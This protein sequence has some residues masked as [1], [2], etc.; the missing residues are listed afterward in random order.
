V[1]RCRYCECMNRVR[2]TQRTSALP[3]KYLSYLKNSSS[4][5]LAESNLSRLLESGGAKALEKIPQADLPTLFAVLGGSAYLSD[6]LFR[7]GNDWPAI[8]LRQL[9]TKSVTVAAHLRELESSIGSAESMALFCAALRRH[10]Q[11]EYLR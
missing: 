1:L 4:P 11:L 8:F 9:R 3:R 6:I 10:K 7:R 5:S 2:K